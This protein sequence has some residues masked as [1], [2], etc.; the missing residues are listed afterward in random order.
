M[1]RARIKRRRNGLKTTV[2]TNIEADYEEYSINEE[3][4]EPIEVDEEETTTTTTTEVDDTPSITF[5]I[6]TLWL[7]II[8]LWVYSWNINATLVS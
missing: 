5:K 8:L 6:I 7:I 3:I 2:P 4:E 1:I